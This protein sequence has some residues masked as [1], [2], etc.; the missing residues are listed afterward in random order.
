MVHGRSVSRYGPR[1]LAR[2]GGWLR[3]AV[4]RML[5]RPEPPAIVLPPRWDE[6]DDDFARS[7]VPRRP[8][9]RSGSGAVALAEPRPEGTWPDGHTGPYARSRRSPIEATSSQALALASLPS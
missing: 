3:R 4:R 5:G 7:G 6:P 1:P 2:L 8:P 9:D